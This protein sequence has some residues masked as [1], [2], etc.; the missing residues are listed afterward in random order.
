MKMSPVVVT[1]LIPAKDHINTCTSLVLCR[2]R[3]ARPHKHLSGR[4]T[5]LSESRACSIRFIFVSRR[6]GV[7]TSASASS[8]L[9]P[10]LMGKKKSSARVGLLV[11]LW[12][13]RHWQVELLLN[14]QRT[15]RSGL[16]SLCVRTVYLPIISRVSRSS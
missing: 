16:N 11:S 9:R 2:A 3:P 12:A 8:T 15:N 10:C 4:A 6:C 5:A 1:C 13:Q 7:R 14:Q